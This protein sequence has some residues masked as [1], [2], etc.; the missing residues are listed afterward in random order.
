M[1]DFYSVAAST[2]KDNSTFAPKMAIYTASAPSWAVFPEGIPKF[3]VLPPE[4]SG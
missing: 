1:A 3:D 4:V 2:L